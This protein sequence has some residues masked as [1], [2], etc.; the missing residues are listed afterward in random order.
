M[1]LVFIKTFPI[2]ENYAKPIHTLRIAGF[3]DF[4]HRPVFYRLENTTFWKLDLFPSSG[5][6]GPL[7]RANL[8]LSKGLN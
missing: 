1:I 7:E 4:F 6:E 8:Y 3:L 2:V 5:E